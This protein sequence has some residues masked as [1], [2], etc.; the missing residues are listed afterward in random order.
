MIF[1]IRR[2][3]KQRVISQ[4]S[5]YVQ[6]LDSSPLPSSVTPSSND[7]IQPQV[8]N[9]LHSFSTLFLNFDQS[10]RGRANELKDLRETVSG[11]TN[12]AGNPRQPCNYSRATTTSQ[13]D[14]AKPFIATICVLGRAIDQAWLGGSRPRDH[15]D[16]HWRAEINDVCRTVVV[17]RNLAG[18]RHVVAAVRQLATCW[19][20]M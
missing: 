18:F 16:F 15:R 2:N 3:T 19:L 6:L 14:P 13:T 5:V 11:A 10:R 20:L 12:V 4:N 8:P 1:K 7:D 9:S 17:G